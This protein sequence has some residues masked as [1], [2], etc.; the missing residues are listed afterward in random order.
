MQSP[1]PFYLMTWVCTS[2]NKQTKILKQGPL[3]FLKYSKLIGLA[4]QLFGLRVKLETFLGD[5]SLV[6][7]CWVI[8]FFARIKNKCME[9]HAK[10]TTLEFNPLTTEI[11]EMRFRFSAIF[12]CNSKSIQ[13]KCLKLTAQKISNLRRVPTLLGT[14][15]R[16]VCCCFLRHSCV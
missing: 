2:K 4:Q 9:N 13:A 16:S 14:E 7:S 3:L 6:F 12:D 15:R 5:F 11:S 10:L 8:Y 1:Q